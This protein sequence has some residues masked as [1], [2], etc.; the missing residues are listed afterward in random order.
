MANQQGKYLAAYMNKDLDPACKPFRYQFMGSMAQLGTW[1][2]VVDGPTVAGKKQRLAGL[3]A[4]LAW[5]SAYWTYSVSNTNKILILM[6][7]F[8]AYWFGRDISKF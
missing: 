8:K 7:W 6:Y 4:F 2:A 1:D 3:T 5:R